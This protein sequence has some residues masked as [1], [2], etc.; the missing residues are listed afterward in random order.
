M[1]CSVKYKTNLIG[2]SVHQSKLD[3]SVMRRFVPSPSRAVSFFG[4]LYVCLSGHVM[5]LSL[6]FDVCVMACH[7]PSLRASLM[8]VL[9]LVMVLVTGPV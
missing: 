5:V 6:Q 9:W 7:G 4:K 8:S 1:P 3:V 2:Q